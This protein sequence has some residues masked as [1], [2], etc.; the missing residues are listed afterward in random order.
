[1][2]GERI[3]PASRRISRRAVLHTGFARRFLQEFLPLDKVCEYHQIPEELLLT[4]IEK[5]RMNP[6]AGP[7]VD[8]FHQYLFQCKIVYRINPCR[9]MK[10]YN[11]RDPLGQFMLFCE[12]GPPLGID[13]IL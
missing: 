9:H 11:K 10:G 12:Y 2:S 8:G 6:V 1:M 7:S 5:K 4:A 3:D 13:G